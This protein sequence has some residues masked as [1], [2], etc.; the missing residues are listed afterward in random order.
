MQPGENASGDAATPENSVP[1]P[2]GIQLEAVD[3]STGETIH[4]DIDSQNLE[5]TSESGVYT[6]TGD[7]YIIIP[8]RG[9]E[10]LA[11]KAT[12][13][14][15]TADVVAVGNVFIISG[16]RVIGSERAQMDLDKNISQYEKARTVTPNYRILADHVVRTDQ[17]TVMQN[18]RFV[19]GA[20][21]FKKV[22]QVF[23]R[24]G[25][26]RFGLGAYFGYFSART[27]RTSALGRPNNLL[28]T[29]A[30]SLYT[31]DDTVLTSQ[32]QQNALQT[33]LQQ[34]PISPRDVV[35]ADFDPEDVRY[36]LKSRNITVY[37]KPDKFDE[38]VFKRTWF[39]QNNVPLMFM[40][41]FTFGYNEDN[42]FLTYLGPEIGYNVDYGG[43]FVGPGWHSR[44]FNGWVKYAPIISY[45]GGT[46]VNSGG[47][48]P[49]QIDPTPGVGF[50][51][52]FR[53][54]TNQT[55]FGISSTLQIPIFL[56]EQRLRDDGSLRLRVGANQ[57]FRSG[58]F[59]LERPKF[60]TELV[61]NKNIGPWNNLFIRTYST[62]GVARD[63]FFPTRRGT[64]FVAPTSNDPITT[65][66]AVTQGQVMTANPLL[67]IGNFARLGAVA[68][69]RLAFYGTG[70]V[71]GIFQ[72]GPYLDVVTGPL[73]NQV[74][75]LYGQTTGR[76]PFV[77]DSYYSGQNSLNLINSLD[78]GKYV[79]VG[80][81]HSLNLNRDNARRDLVVDQKIFLSFGPRHLRFSLAFDIIQRRSYFGIMLNPEGGQLVMDFDTLTMY[82]P[83]YK[84]VR[85]DTSPW[86]AP[87]EPKR[88]KP[89]Q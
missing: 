4:I 22:S 30:G 1:Q 38:I 73:L 88:K 7:V 6:V 36:R 28:A 20:E 61:H 71:F 84:P 25:G 51:G 43:L 77:F 65:F 80:A 49:S 66:R 79:T 67:R 23:Q 24:R 58:F 82:Q 86:V 37:R 52:R 39:R 19:M 59:A 74:T 54:R 35:S 64:F 81:T 32:A 12:Y 60:I 26:L 55:D 2:Q 83:D 13:N 21:E 46:R 89:K 41:S 5:Y 63:E 40:P 3:P 44:L 76:T 33:E 68:Q 72:G 56:S 31:L 42:H 48:Q 10:I 70:D 15:T 14:P 75:Y 34:K 62:L 50:I 87:R 16:D 78:L 53:S 9:I 8:E 57:Y 17:F 27:Y 29:S 47:N 18:G 69:G 85:G 11:D 45:G